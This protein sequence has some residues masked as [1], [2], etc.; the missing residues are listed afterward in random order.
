MKSKFILLKTI[1]APIVIILIVLSFSSCKK[2]KL[3]IYS[4]QKFSQLDWKKSSD[5]FYDNPYQLTLSPGNVADILPGGDVIHRGTYKISGSS[6][7]VKA[8]G[9]TYKFEILSELE[10]KEL[11]NN[12][13]LRLTDY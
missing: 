8:D 2:D 10:V 9:E 7:T 12:I 1:I 11:S 6:I 3:K 5:S 13:V 4:V